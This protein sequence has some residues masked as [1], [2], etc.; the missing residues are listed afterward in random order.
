MTMEIT[1]D[2]KGLKL[3]RRHTLVPNL[4]SRIETLVIAVK[5]HVK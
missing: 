4:S 2:W 5:K 3:T 1:K